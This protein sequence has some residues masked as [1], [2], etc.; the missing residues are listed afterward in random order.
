MDDNKK[1]Y[2]LDVM[3]WV[4]FPLTLVVWSI[5]DSESLNEVIDSEVV[6]FLFVIM[7]ILDIIT[8]IAY[9]FRKN[10]DN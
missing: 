5:M 1:R 3:M 2:F 7:V 8:L 4:V 6:K 9:L 10:K